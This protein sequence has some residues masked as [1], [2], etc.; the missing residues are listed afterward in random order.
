MNA[1]LEADVARLYALDEQ[2]LNDPFPIYARLRAE[3]PVSR[4]GAVVSIARYDDVKAVLR[5]YEDFT[6]RKD[7]GSIVEQRRAELSGDDLAKLEDV[8][9]KGIGHW[10]ATNDEPHHSHL[11]G[12]V[13]EVFSAQRVALMREEIETISEELLDEIV[14][15]A[16]EVEFDLVEQYAFRMPLIVICRVL[17]ADP[18]DAAKLRQWSDDLGTAIGTTY[19]NLDEAHE[20]FENFRSYVRM[21]IERVHADDSR[22]DLFSDIVRANHDGETLS[23]DDLIAIF[24]HLIFAGHET[25]TNLIGNAMNT[26]LDHPDQLDVLRSDPDLI[27]HA[28]DEFLRF[29]PSVHAIHRVATR[30]VDVAGFTIREGETVRLLL[31]SAN[32]DTAVFTDPDVLDVRRK[33]V[34]RHLGLGYGIHTCLGAW[35]TRLEIEIAIRSLL[36]RFASVERRTP[37]RVRPNLTLYGAPELRLRARVA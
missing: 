22:D 17:G 35:L 16:T 37:F 20:A 32:R 6:S 25:T 13:D 4:V 31:G 29:C 8:A 9:V 3:A 26:L 15:S 1:D 11:R 27:R 14:G 30:D 12:F 21:T 36:T 23:E 10:M 24:T 7:G 19:A 2:A 5:N 33:N 18:A 34:R 28:A